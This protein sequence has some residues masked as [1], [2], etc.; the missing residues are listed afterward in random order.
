MKK[1]EKIKII[2]DYLEGETVKQIASKYN[3]R[4]PDV[5]QILKEAGVFQRGAK[6]RLGRTKEQEVCDLYQKGNCNMKTLAQKYKTS[7]HI[8]KTIL[9]KN[10]I[11]INSYKNRHKNIG[12]Q[13]DYFEVIDSELKAYLLGFIFADGCVHKNE[14]SIEVNEKDIS[15]LH[16]F[17]G[18]INSSAKITRRERSTGT[19]VCTRACSAKMVSD[20]EKYGIVPNKTYIVKKLPDVEE[21]YLRHLLRGY[22]D[23]DGWVIYDKDKNYHTIGVVSYFEST[24]QDFREKCN[25]LLQNQITSKIQANEDGSRLNCSNKKT[26]KELAQLLYGDANYYLIRKYKKAQKIIELDEDIV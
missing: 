25:H 20:L 4:N 8:I 5:S 16:L 21:L 19:M 11:P 2:E 17:N 26:V 10:N 22:V 18:A 13:E 12:L 6:K 14:L 3:Y 24:C 15:I 9:V 23:G 1:E 7:S